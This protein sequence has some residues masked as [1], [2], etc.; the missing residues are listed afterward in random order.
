MSNDGRDFI[1]DAPRTPDLYACD[2]TL[3]AELK[4]RVSEDT[5][6]KTTPR[7][8]ALGQAT[9]GEMVELANAAESNPPV[10]VPFDPWGRRV[11][12]IDVH[13]AWDK[14][15]D[16]A[17]THGIVATGYDESLGEQR[18]VVQAALLHLYSAS[19]A[20][21]SCPLAMT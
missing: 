17:A 3:R 19:S 8:A 11:D 2:P 4:K 21:F 16:L 14:L 15:K 18:R 5:L 6:N 1:Q 7:L 13:P 9:A 10:H 20:T 12:R